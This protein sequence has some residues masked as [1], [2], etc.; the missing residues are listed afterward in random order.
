MDIGQLIYPY[1][2]LLSNEVAHTATLGPD[3]WW[4]VKLKEYSFI[5][6]IDIY[7]RQDCCSARLDGLR[8]YV[9]DVLVI[10][11]KYELN[12]N[13]YSYPDLNVAGSEITI[14]GGDDTINVAEVE[15]YGPIMDCKLI[16][17]EF[18]KR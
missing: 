10:T 17:I 5:N 3:A 7:N 15:V 6:K 2:S 4:K 1:S 9:G 18:S 13:P 14:R 16:K 11:I 8:V 12:K